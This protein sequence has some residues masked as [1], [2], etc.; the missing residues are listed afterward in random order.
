MTRDSFIT[1]LNP[2]QRDAVLH[3]SS[4]L[5]ILAGAGSG[6][7]RVIAAKYAYLISKKNLKPSNILTISFT[8]KAAQEMKERIASL[9]S[10]DL[11]HSNIGTFHSQCARILRKEINKLGYD[12]DFVIYDEQD[13][14][15]LLKHI[16][17]ELKMYEAL[18]KGVAS[19]I[20][21]LK[22]QLVTPEGFVSSGDSFGFDE[23]LARVYMRYQYELK[24]SNALDFDD[25]IMLT[26]VLF[27]EH[28]EVA[29]QYRNAFK[30]ILI[31][32][33][34][35]TNIAQYAFL[36]KLSAD[37]GDFC[38]VGDDD[39][40]IYKFRGA[41]VRNILTM[42]RDFPN[43][44]IIKLERNYRSTQNILDVSHSIISRNPQRRDKKLWTDRGEGEKV[45]QYWFGTEVEEAKYVAKMI[46]EMY[47]K[48]K[49]SYQDIAIFYRVNIQSR[50]LEEALKSE[51]IPYRIVGGIG[52]YQ[53][54][55]IK[56]TLSYM[57][58]CINPHDNVS[59]RRVINYPPRGIGAA[60]LN[61][62]ESEAKKHNKSLFDTM[63]DIGNS[64]SIS[65]SVKEKLFGFMRV[66][67]TIN[68][69]K[70]P[71]A[72]QM[73]KRILDDTG[74]I[75]S[76]SD[77]R[78]KNIFELVAS[79]EEVSVDEFVDAIALITNLDDTNTS[80]TV[81]LM[82]LHTAKGLEYPVVFIVGIEEG[83]I[84]YFK[85]VDD[86]SEMHEERRLFYVGITRAKNLLYLS[87]SSK[88]RLYSKI[89]V[90]EPSRFMKDIPV[91]YCKTAAKCKT[92]EIEKQPLQQLKKIAFTPQY[93][94]GCR[95]KHPK[96]GVGVV[97]DCYGEGD[98]LK[99]MVNFPNVGIKRLALKF[100]QLERV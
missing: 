56:D 38:A 71:S 65:P 11:H 83:I 4:P 92:D 95:V 25:L 91:Q 59:L 82:T 57:R 39:Q 40:S 90:Q 26:V 32:E 88:R 35:D 49:Y 52:F 22:A 43:L 6:K 93:K 33:F 67:E 100:A 37:R 87:G 96:W 69:E 68:K 98:D 19:R 77:E 80:N 84:P 28:P 85:A 66:V 76:L 5:L 86:P 1:E 60:T 55:E 75:D 8:N 51:R 24:R 70:F 10:S 15:S 63:K 81:S 47:L 48:G 2:E 44:R 46:K 30:Y 9:V 50:A 27:E 17:R 45:N 20:S 12:K 97:R 62:I 53:K 64:K 13:T 14:C 78:V 31:D 23:K 42:E 74:Y 18:Y 41:D 89:Q 34:Q 3:S 72:A 94:T 16:L 7:T 73:L 36:K 29:T 79:A 99:L 61:K 54:K 21:A 58:L